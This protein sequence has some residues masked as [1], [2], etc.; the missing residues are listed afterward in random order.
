M[1]A[2]YGSLPVAQPVARRRV[3]LL[4]IGGAA[5]AIVAVSALLLIVAQPV[6]ISVISLAEIG[7]CRCRASQQQCPA[8]MGLLDGS[9]CIGSLSF[10]T[11][12][13]VYALS[14]PDMLHLRAQSQSILANV[15]KDDGADALV[16]AI[17]VARGD[18][19]PTQF[20][21]NS[22]RGRFCSCC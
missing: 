8:R 13:C 14:H 10:V 15:N 5:T 18:A 9:S 12:C 6:P 21:G 16:N 19:L 11:R 4:A 20:A 17:L 2:G 22:E 1:Q 3:S 7:W